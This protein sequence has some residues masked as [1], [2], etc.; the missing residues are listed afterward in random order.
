MAKSC[1]AQG[2]LTSGRP[3]SCS[4]N[5]YSRDGRHDG[6]YSRDDGRERMMSQLEEMMDNAGSEKARE[7]IR[8]CMTQLENA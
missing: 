1:A 8:R 5:N 3:A 7:A 4:S 6:R 2:F